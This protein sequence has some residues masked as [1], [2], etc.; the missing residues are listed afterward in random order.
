[1]G[2]EFRGGVFKEAARASDWPARLQV[3][4]CDGSLEVT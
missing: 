2:H 4:D 3:R 1:M